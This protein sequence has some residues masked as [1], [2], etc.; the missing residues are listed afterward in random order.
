MPDGKPLPAIV[1]NGNIIPDAKALQ[2]MFEERMPPTHYE[3]QS[4]DCQVL[5]PNYMGDDTASNS[6]AKGRNMT[7]LVIVSGYVKIGEPRE[8]AMR[9]F[10]ETFVLVPNPDIT[11]VK[12]RGKH[13]K[14]FLIQ[15]DTLRLVV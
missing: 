6:R 3:V 12:G 10:S 2:S 5:N 14:E 4:Y 15:S 7:I 11:A 1:F 13:M 8:A 9:G